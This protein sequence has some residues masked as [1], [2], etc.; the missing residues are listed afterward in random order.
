MILDQKILDALYGSEI[1][2]IEFDFKNNTVSFLFKIK[3]NKEV[4][5]TL[6]LFEGVSKYK[7]EKEWVDEVWDIISVAEILHLPEIK[8]NC[9]INEHK[10]EGYNYIIDGEGF[11]ILI[12][13]NSTNIKKNTTIN[14][15]EQPP[16]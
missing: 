2:L 8:N 3:E 6:L 5:K 7:I 4:T 12:K 10:N 9:G 15:M 11:K 1:D 14:H 13:A 16:S